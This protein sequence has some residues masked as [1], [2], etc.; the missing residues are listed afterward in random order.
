MTLEVEQLYEAASE[1]RQ[2]C[3]RWT[4]WLAQC[5]LASLVLGQSSS[6]HIYCEH[7]VAPFLGCLN[8]LAIYNNLPFKYTKFLSSG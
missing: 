7:R 4:P 5:K 8:A 6:S 1:L 2:C 3:Q